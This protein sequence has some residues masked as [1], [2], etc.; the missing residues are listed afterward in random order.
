M[1]LLAENTRRKARSSPPEDCLNARD[2]NNVDADAEDG[3][4][5]RG[6]G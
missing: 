5:R 4:D 3:H 1:F 2:V 6:E